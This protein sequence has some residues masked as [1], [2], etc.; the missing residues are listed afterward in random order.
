MPQSAKWFAGYLISPRFPT[1]SLHT[2]KTPDSSTTPSHHQAIMP[3][4]TPMEVLLFKDKN[5]I[6]HSFPVPSNLIRHRTRNLF[7]PIDDPRD[8]KKGR[9]SNVLKDLTLPALHIFIYWIYTGRLPDTAREAE[10]ESANAA[11]AATPTA[12]PADSSIVPPQNGRAPAA[13]PPIPTPTPA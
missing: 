13:A 2:N 12:P 4:P 3:T 11:A 5:S 9:P 7:A 10:L 1:L 6:L 8:G